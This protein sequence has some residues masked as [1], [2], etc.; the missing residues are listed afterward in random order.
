MPLNKIP[1]SCA[2]VRKDFFKVT[3]HQLTA[4]ILNQLIY[5]TERRKD[6]LEF[7]EETL[8]KDTKEFGWVYKTASDLKEEVLTE[9]SRMSVSRALIRLEALGILDVRN[10]PSNHFNRA[11]QYRVNLEKLAALVKEKGFE[12]S[13]YASV[14]KFFNIK[15][16]SKENS[17]SHHEQCSMHTLS[18]PLHNVSNVY[19]ESEITKTEIEILNTVDEEIKAVNLKEYKDKKEKNRNLPAGTLPIWAKGLKDEAFYIQDLGE[20]VVNIRRIDFHEL[21]DYY[22]KSSNYLEE[23]FCY[24]LEKRLTKERVIRTMNKF[25]D[26]PDCYKPSLES[27]ITRH[28][29]EVDSTIEDPRY[30]SL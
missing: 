10:D 13:K 3:N 6:F 23:L 8:T 22:C 28:T 14:K 2:V 30:A 27:I 26:K 5:W 9:Q 16:E 19:K 12:N 18:F 29:P 11:L 7:K 17:I 20:N 4:I 21:R 24:F 25:S 15:G 1:T